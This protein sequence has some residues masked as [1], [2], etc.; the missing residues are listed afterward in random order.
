[1]LNFVLIIIK[2]K[3]E[4]GITRRESPIATLITPKTWSTS[5]RLPPKTF[6]WSNEFSQLSPLSIMLSPSNIGTWIPSLQGMRVDRNKHRLQLKKF[7]KGMRVNGKTNFCSRKCFKLWKDLWFLIK[8][9]SS[10][11]L[12]MLQFSKDQDLRVVLQPKAKEVKLGLR[13][14]PTERSPPRQEWAQ[15]LLILCN[16][17][18]A[19]F[20]FKNKIFAWSII[21]YWWSLL[22]LCQMIWK[23]GIPSTTVSKRRSLK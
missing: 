1:M 10:Q 5:T 13:G 19:H 3:W 12:S 9:P 8:H 17:K 20:K 21:S 22:Y 16:V 23:D 15:P 4:I 14:A 18:R 11:R 7:W 2:F 6:I